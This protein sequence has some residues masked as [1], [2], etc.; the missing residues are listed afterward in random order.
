MMTTQKMVIQAA[1]GT[2][3]VQNISTVLTA[4][5]SFAIVMK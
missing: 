2:A 3:V 4:W 5:S 1:I